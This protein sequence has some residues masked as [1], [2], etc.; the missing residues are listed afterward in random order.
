VVIQNQE[1]CKFSQHSTRRSHTQKYK[2]LK[3][4][5]GKVYDPLLI[6]LPLQHNLLHKARTDKRPCTKCT[7]TLDKL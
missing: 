4:G 7:F 5:G 6:K 1:K 2:R 3:H